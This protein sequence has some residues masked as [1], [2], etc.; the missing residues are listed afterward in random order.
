MIFRS[1]EP[2]MLKA[3]VNLKEIKRVISFPRGDTV[4]G[5]R[6]LIIRDYSDLLL[7]TVPPAC[8]QIQQWDETVSDDIDLPI[9]LKLE[10]D[11]KVKVKLPATQEEMVIC[12][13]GAVSRSV[14][15]SPVRRTPSRTR[16][17]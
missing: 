7:D 3:H 9:Q 13:P 14:R 12:R 8:V 5:L 2:E 17:N 1:K 11:V 4:Q 6:Y 15:G 10:E 16:A